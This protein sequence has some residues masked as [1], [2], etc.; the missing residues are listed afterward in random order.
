MNWT[1]RLFWN[2]REVLNGAATAVC[3]Y[4]TAR[5][6]MA[7]NFAGMQHKYWIEEHFGENSRTF[8]NVLKNF[9]VTKVYRDDTGHA[10]IEIAPRPII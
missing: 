9:N 7:G 5:G 3:A 8:E 6:F 10:Q 2:G 1:I 4:E